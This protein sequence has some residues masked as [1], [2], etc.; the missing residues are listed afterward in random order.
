MRLLHLPIGA[1]IAASAV[2]TAGCGG[3]NSSSNA[4]APVLTFV[5][6]GFMYVANQGSN[7]V[8]GYAIGANG[9]LTPV[10]GSPFA[11]A[12][13]PGGVATDPQGRFVYVTDAV[14]NKISAYTITAKTG[15][16][17]PVPGSP[18]ASVAVPTGI[19][20]DPTGKVA[21][22]A[23]N[24]ARSISAYAIDQTTG[25][26]TAIGG[27]VA[28]GVEP[29]GVA[30]DP[31]GKYVYVVNHKSGNVSEYAIN[32]TSGALTPIAGSP[33][34]AAYPSTGVSVSP[35][36]KFVYVTSTNQQSGTTTSVYGYAINASTGAL[37][38][39]GGSPYPAGVVPP[40]AYESTGIAFTP[41]GNSM[42]VSSDEVMTNGNSFTEEYTLSPYSV[43]AS[44]GVPTLGAAQTFPS[45]GQSNGPT[46]IGNVAGGVAV[47][48][49]GS[50]VYVADIDTNAIYGYAIG[51][52]GALTPIAGSPFAAGTAPIG[53]AI[54]RTQSQT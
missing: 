44:S 34:A 41:S 10:P 3:G 5:V 32:A 8:S 17:V 7:T 54:A 43:D 6:H 29:F 51:A 47:D 14:A 4:I 30:V 33:V 12:A 26:L 36:G 16:L 19:A 28:A 18:F 20:V 9:Q 11:S 15:A 13:G 39:L 48:G 27:P 38:P 24:Q 42:F 52:G 35:N 22:V 25:A 31:S 49:S 21:Y 23:N 1:L 45:T 46:D 53:I 2:A 37:S 40:G 50:F